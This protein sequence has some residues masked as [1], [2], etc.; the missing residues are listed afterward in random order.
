MRKVT[1]AILV[2]YEV[3]GDAAAGVVG[4]HAVQLM[5]ALPQ[6]HIAHQTICTPVAV[7][8]LRAD[9]GP[10]RTARTPGRRADTRAADAEQEECPHA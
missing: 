6:F 10:A 7:G 3:E 1:V 5:P 4:Q 2:E 8:I 9:D